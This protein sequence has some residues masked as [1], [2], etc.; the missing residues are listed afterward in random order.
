MHDAA[1]FTDSHFFNFL[2]TTEEV[3][4]QVPQHHL[5]MQ[6]GRGKVNTMPCFIEPS[7]FECYGKNM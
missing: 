1:F 7:Q 2:V 5:V 6:A 4:Q 3:Y